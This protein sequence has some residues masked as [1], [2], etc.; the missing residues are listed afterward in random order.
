MTVATHRGDGL[1]L[2]KGL[3][4][5]SIACLFWSSLYVRIDFLAPYG[6]ADLAVVRFFFSSVL[7]LALGIRRRRLGGEL[8]RQS[9]RAW[10]VAGGLGFIGFTGYFFF[11]ATAVKFTS[12]IIAVSIIGL[13]SVLT[14]VVN[15][16]LYRVFAWRVVFWPVAAGLL[17]VAAIVDSQI[18][19]QQFRLSSP[20][21]GIGLGAALIAL[22]MWSGYQVLNKRALLRHPD[23]SSEAWTLM[24]LI[25]GAAL[26]PLLVIVLPF[27]ALAGEFQLFS[28]EPTKA[29]YVLIGWGGF[30][31]I[32][33]S[34][35]SLYAW[36][37]AQKLLPPALSGQSIAFLLPLVFALG[38]RYGRFSNGVAE[39]VIGIFLL[40]L[41][42][43]MTAWLQARYRSR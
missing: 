25:G 40:L 27:S 21:A 3:A 7:A 28:V 43:A 9:R 31:A 24:T 2:A 13:I 18:E 26:L 11:L 37:T 33:A 38:W 36:N 12:E 23:V 10:L 29:L 8:L 20:G 41:S 22:L 30:L 5:A 16:G 1:G 17:G 15:N 39:A 34:L 14:L 19:S 6:T 32:G 42:V 4:L 35:I